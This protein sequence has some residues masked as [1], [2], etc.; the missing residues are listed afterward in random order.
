MT[1][2]SITLDVTKINKDK[3]IERT[4]KNSSGQEVT[5]KEYKMDLVPLK[6]PKVLKE[7]DTWTLKK[8]HFLAEQREK[9]ETT[10]ENNYV[11]EGFQFFDRTPAT[12]ELNA[13]ETSEFLHESDIPF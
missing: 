12:E 2:I 6:E 7:G 8:T 11:G 10:G 4:Y 13:T 9:G 5:V 1:K 3:I